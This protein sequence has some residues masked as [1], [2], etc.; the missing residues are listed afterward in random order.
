MTIIV[1]KQGRRLQ[2]T[3]KI[4]FGSEMDAI[5]NARLSCQVIATPIF[6]HLTGVS[7]PQGISH[8]SKLPFISI[9]KFLMNK[10]VLLLETPQTYLSNT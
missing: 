1:Q 4:L 8:P 6:S 2:T 9:L 5:N 10:V 7:C 3:L